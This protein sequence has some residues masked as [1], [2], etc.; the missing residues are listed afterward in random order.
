M[1]RTKDIMS[2][3]PLLACILGKQY[4]ITV[5][6]G[7]TTAYT[8][9]K[10]IHIPSLKIDTDEMYINMTRGYVD[11]EAAHIRYTD[12]QLLQ[13]ANLT[14]L[15]FHL[16]NIIEDWRVETLLG[17]HF[18]GCRKNFDFIIV[19]L[20]GKERQK[21]GSNAPAFFVLEYIL[22]TIRSWNSSEVEKNRTLSRKEMVTACLGIEKELDACLKK[23]HANTRTTQDAIAHALLLESIIKKWIPEQPQGST[24]QMEKRND[25]LDGEQSVISEE[26]EGAQDAYEDSFPKT[27]G[28]VLREKLSAQAEGMDS[29]HWTVAKIRPVTP[30]VIPP[31]M[32]RR[33]ELI[34]RGLSIRIQGLMQSLSMSASYPSTKGRL[35]TAKL[36]RIKAENPKVFIQRTECVAV[37]TSLHILLDASASMY[38]K[39]MELAT[40]SCHAIASACSAIKGLNTAV[41][42]FNGNYR[43]DVGL[44]YPLLKH[45]HPVHAR[46]NLMP[47]GG[48]PL[49]PA[50]WW[51]M[52]QLLFTKERRK[53]LFVLTDGQPTDMTAT[54]KALKMAHKIGLEVYGLGILDDS[55]NN[56]LPDASRVIYQLEE[57]PAML[58][59]LLHDVLTRKNGSC[60]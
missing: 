58:F 60:L 11:H 4:N 33:T 22:L 24:S 50:L 10:T 20:F 14:R 48:T 57:L 51:V 29:E 21:A 18:P 17:K 52:Q 27:M 36:Y 56:I 45:G 40:A 26:K 59:E 39:P 35:N 43:G 30:D 38:G 49:A 42:A 34:T 28:A 54:K 5:E 16:F 46:F 55:I 41:T 13:K 32:L 12:F 31:D 2:C 7:G 25:H 23:I 37:N 19:Y 47:S 15:Q 8:N 44:V 53:M 3:L 9:G 1:L 6:I